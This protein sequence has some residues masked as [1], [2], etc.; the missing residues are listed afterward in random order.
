MVEAD[1]QL[2][3]DGGSGLRLCQALTVDKK[4]VLWD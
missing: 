2:F 1:N 3:F 4:E